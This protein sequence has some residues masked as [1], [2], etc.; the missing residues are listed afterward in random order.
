MRSTRKPK[1]IERIRAIS[2]S[3]LMEVEADVAPMR[4]LSLEERGERLVAVCRAAW[5][6]LRSRPDFKQAVAYSDP[7]PTDFPAKWQ[8]LVARRRAQQRMNL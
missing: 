6:V 8:A 5:A 1:F 3:P 4:G 7:V 2:R